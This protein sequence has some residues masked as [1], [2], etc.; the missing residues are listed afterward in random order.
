MQAVSAS[1]ILPP[2]AGLDR[3]QHAIVHAAHLL[4]E[5]EPIPVFIHHNTLHAFEE[6]RFSDAVV[7]G[8]EVFGCEPFLSEARYRSEYA[9]G[10]IRDVDLDAV[11]R[12]ELGTSCNHAVALGCTRLQLWHTL[13]HAPKHEG[14]AAEFH[15]FM[16]ETDALERFRPEVSAADR[17]HLIAETQHWTLRDLRGG[18][19]SSPVTSELLELLSH[20]NVE[21]WRDREWEAFSLQSLWRIC[22]A[23]VKQIELEAQVPAIPVRHRDLLLAVA[24]VDTDRVV[25][26]LLVRFSRHT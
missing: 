6:L 5:Q 9:R 14:T 2:A 25:H 7:K 17:A 12:E 23:G 4:P 18:T 22:F 13:L 15:W 21:Q 11:L 10:R 20:G 24:G 19:A 16:A 3:L 1:P 8:S 26:D